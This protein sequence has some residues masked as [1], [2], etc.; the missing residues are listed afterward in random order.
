MKKEIYIAGG[1]FWGVQK[2][3]DSVKGVL[4]TTVGYLNSNMENPT[5]QDVCSKKTNAV[6]AVHIIYDDDVILLFELIDHWMSIID[7]FSVNKQ[8]NDVG[9]QYRTGIY[10]KD[11]TERELMRSYL[12]DLQKNFNKPLA[13]EVKLVEN[14]YLAEE[15]H[16]K[17]LEKNPNGYC[18]I[19]LK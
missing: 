9:T 10:T 5:Y 18:H 14:Y 1:C 8:G 7:P 16:Q 17:Y 15:Y 13:I 12:L 11:N 19:K 3:F 4:Q 2:Y 6:E